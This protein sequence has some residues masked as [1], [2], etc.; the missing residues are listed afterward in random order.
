M[1]I[2]VMLLIKPAPVTLLGNGYVGLDSN[3]F[4]CPYLVHDYCKMAFHNTFYFFTKN[5]IEA[6]RFQSY[7]PTRGINLPLSA[8]YCIAFGR[9]SA[10]DT[11]S[12]RCSVGPSVS[13]DVSVQLSHRKLRDGTSR[14]NSQSMWTDFAL[15]RRV[16]F[17]SSSSSSYKTNQC[18]RQYQ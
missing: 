7:P 12:A 14:P 18:L 11:T 8:R 15:S 13:Y 1:M 5:V 17:S 9:S 2:P 3:Q 6:S 16:F 10:P 4:V